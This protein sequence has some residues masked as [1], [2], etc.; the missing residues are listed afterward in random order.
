LFR[1]RLWQAS[2]YDHVLRGDEENFLVTRYMFNNPIRAGL[3]QR[4]EEYPF[5]GSTTTPVDEIFE[6]TRRMPHA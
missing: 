1:G 3:V 5:L 2:F 6:A 4:C